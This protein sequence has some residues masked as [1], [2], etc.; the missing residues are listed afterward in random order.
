[1]SDKHESLQRHSVEES[2]KQVAVDQ[3]SSSPKIVAFR[4]NYND[5]RRIVRQNDCETT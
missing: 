5:V 4:G 1:M 2:L 3:L